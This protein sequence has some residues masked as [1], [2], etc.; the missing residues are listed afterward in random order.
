[1]GECGI[2]FFV[3]SVHCLY[4]GGLPYT[5]PCLTLGSSK[6]SATRINTDFFNF[7]KKYFAKCLD[8]RNALHYL[9][10]QDNAPL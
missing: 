2:F 7:L 9:C 4:I 6:G 8:I 3:A 10:S 5:L 1:M